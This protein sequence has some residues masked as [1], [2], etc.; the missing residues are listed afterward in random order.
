MS[1]KAMI[2][3][4]GKIWHS[5]VQVESLGNNLVL[6]TCP[7]GHKT[8]INYGK[9]PCGPISSALLSKFIRMWNDRVTIIC[10]KGSCKMRR[11]A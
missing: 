6:F 4:C 3:R 10:C 8:R 1:T 11:T 7:D 9:R 5:G 2:E